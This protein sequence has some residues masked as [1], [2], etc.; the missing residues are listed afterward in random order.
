MNKITALI[1]LALLAAVSLGAPPDP[2]APPPAL[3]DAALRLKQAY[4]QNVERSLR[5]LR[6]RYFAELRRAIDAATRA[7]HLDVALAIS[8]ELDA[9]PGAAAA[10][11]AA[12]TD[13]ETK[14]VG[15][16]WMAP[17]RSQF[18]LLADGKADGRTFTWKVAS[19]SA[20]ELDSHDGSRGSIVFDPGLT[21]GRATQT[22]AT[23]QSRSLILTRVR[24]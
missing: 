1:F 15:S 13:L 19:P 22:E 20:V 2:S 7:G 12:L 4:Q 9:T 17:D 18:T 3:P 8:T 10:A 24:K 5:P 21:T 16:T 11:A 23:G 6:D 14:L